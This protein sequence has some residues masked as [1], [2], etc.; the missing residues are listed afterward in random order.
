MITLTG[1]VRALP[2]DLRP[3]GVDQAE[4]LDELR[5][6]AHFVEATAVTLS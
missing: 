5:R 3:F 2:S 4:G 6:R 1:T